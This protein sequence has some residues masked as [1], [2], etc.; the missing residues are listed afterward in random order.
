M[1]TKSGRVVTY[2]KKLPSIKSG[3]FYHVFWLIILISLIRFVGLGRKR[4]SRH[5]LLILYVWNLSNLIVIRDLS[6]ISHLKKTI[7]NTHSKSMLKV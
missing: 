5:Q 2:N 4:L 6:F 3:S 7:F 1:A